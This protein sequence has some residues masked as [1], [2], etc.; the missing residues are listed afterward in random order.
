MCRWTSA[1]IG[2]RLAD[3][4]AAGHKQT[5]ADAAADGNHRQ[6]AGFQMALDLRVVRRIR[7]NQKQ[8]APSGAAFY[9]RKV[10]YYI[11]QP[12]FPRANVWF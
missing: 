5:R 12:L 8:A 7:H 9:K 3:G 4:G 11:K 2:A 1:P 6:M 10:Q